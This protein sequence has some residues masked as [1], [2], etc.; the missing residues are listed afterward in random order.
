MHKYR[1][2]FWP[3]FAISRNVLGKLVEVKDMFTLRP[4][5]STEFEGG[6]QCDSQICWEAH[7]CKVLPGCVTADSK[8]PM[9]EHVT[10]NYIRI[11][12][13][14]ILTYLNVSF[15]FF[16][17]FLGPG[18]RPRPPAAAGRARAGRLPPLW[19]LGLGSGPENVKEN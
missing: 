13:N 12:F 11:R 5:P 8:T 19:G 7:I 10:L 3:W 9:G 6:S 4:A 18:T 15:S 16:F 1:V 17:T 2:T 14:L